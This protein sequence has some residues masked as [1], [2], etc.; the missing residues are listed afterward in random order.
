MKEIARVRDGGRGGERL[1]VLVRR[2]SH[3][4]NVLWGYS[5]R[6]MLTSSRL[7][8]TRIRTGWSRARPRPPPPGARSASFS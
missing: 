6:A 4:A 2:V 5:R 3:A 7:V 1:V 8:T